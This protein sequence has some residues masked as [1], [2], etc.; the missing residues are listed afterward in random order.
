MEDYHPYDGMSDIEIYRDKVEFI[1][2]PGEFPPT[3]HRFWEVVF[4]DECMYKGHP[5]YQYMREICLT[6]SEI[7][8][9]IQRRFYINN[10]TENPEEVKDDFIKTDNKLDIFEEMSAREINDMFDFHTDLTNFSWLRDGV[11]SIIDAGEGTKNIYHCEEENCWKLT[12][13]RDD[14]EPILNRRAQTFDRH[15]CREF[16]ADVYSQ[17]PIADGESD[18]VPRTNLVFVTNLRK[19]NYN[20]RCGD[21]TAAPLADAAVQDAIDEN[22]LIPVD[23]TNNPDDQKLLLRM[24]TPEETSDEVIEK[25]FEIEKLTTENSVKIFCRRF[26]RTDT[27]DTDLEKEDYGYPRVPVAEVWGAYKHLCDINDV[28]AKPEYAGAKQ[29][30][31]KQVDVEKKPARWSKTDNQRTQCFVEVKLTTGGRLLADN[32]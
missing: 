22:I 2:F 23:P 3:D 32:R 19:Y 4:D 31:Q 28:E 27:D 16:W 21:P 29:E 30:I 25:V 8:R 5:D 11:D 26:L 18:V 12:M 15:R 13:G 7:E 1:T 10:F 24:P 20:A 14:P 9:S 17:V 6:K